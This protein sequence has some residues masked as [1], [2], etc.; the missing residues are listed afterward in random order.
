MVTLL[1]FMRIDKILAERSAFF[2]AQKIRMVVTTLLIVLL[3][4]NITEESLT[5]AKELD[6][7]SNK[8]RSKQI[9]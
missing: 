7:S 8:I 3:L 1:T 9:H 2:T 4:Q 6:L 5:M